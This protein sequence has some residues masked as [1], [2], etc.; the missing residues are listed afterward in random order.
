MKVKRVTPLTSAFLAATFPL[1]GSLFA[2]DPQPA[3]PPRPQP[4][5]E[6]TQMSTQAEVKTFS[7]K[8]SKS[9]GKYVLEDTRAN[10]SYILDDQK[11]AKKYDGKAVLV[12]GTLDTSNNTIHVQ[13]IEAAA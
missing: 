7:G 11:T 4:P 9:K 2:Q 12:T 13:K 8:I 1:A 5:H 6:Q 3:Y 10:S